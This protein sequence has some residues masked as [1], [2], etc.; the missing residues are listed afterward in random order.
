VSKVCHVQINDETFAARQGDLLLDAALASGIDLPHDCRSG[1]C[2]TCKVRVLSGHTFGGASRDP[3]VVH[4]CQ[5]R[6]VSD[7][8]VAV[9]EVPAAVQLDGR[10]RELRR[11]APDVFEVAIETREPL[12]HFPGQYVQMQF[13]GYPLRHYS[14]TAPLDGAQPRDVMR[15]HIRQFPSGRVSSELGRGIAAGHRVRITGPY[16]TAYFRPRNASR[17]VLVSS[18]TGFAP[19]WAVADAAIREWPEREL[20]LIAS[21]RSLASLYMIPALCQLARLPRATITLVSSMRQNFTRAVRYGRPTDYMPPLRHDDLVYVAG[22]PAMVEAVAEMSHAAGATCL[23]DPFEPAGTGAGEGATF[24]AKA[25]E[26]FSFRPQSE[27]EQT[28][29]TQASS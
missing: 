26:W 21:A 9:D 14:P 16:G 29:Q 19:I 8:R 28:T 18:G 20:V 12:A 10:V 17:I 4:A 23:A 2:G 25:A 13:R 24:F 6:I 1:Y 5:S 27:R 7:L 3:H 22:A 15:F 11:I